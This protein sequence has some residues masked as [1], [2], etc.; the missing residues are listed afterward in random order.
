MLCSAVA[1]E[2]RMREDPE[3]SR[4]RNQA[5]YALVVIPFD[6][7]FNLRTP[8]AITRIVNSIPSTRLNSLMP[9]RQHPISEQR[10]PLKRNLIELF[11]PLCGY[12]ISLLQRAFDQVWLSAPEHSQSLTVARVHPDSN[13]ESCATGTIPAARASGRLIQPHV[14]TSR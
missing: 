13:R 10:I 6:H 1:P 12:A 11:V 5:A 8:R 4:L 3:Q 2:V 14:R 7:V 9:V